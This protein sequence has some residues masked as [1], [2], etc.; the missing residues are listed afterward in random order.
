[1][2]RILQDQKGRLSVTIPKVVAEARDIKGGDEIEWLVNDWD[3]LV[4][5]KLKK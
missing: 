2:S 3:Q 5:R 1:M 4:I